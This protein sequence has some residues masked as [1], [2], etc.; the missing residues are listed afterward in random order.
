MRRTAAFRRRQF[1]GFI[2]RCNQIGKM[3]ETQLDE[4][5]QRLASFTIKIVYPSATAKAIAL[6]KLAAFAAFDEDQARLI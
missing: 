3:D 4:E 5:L 1:D 6:V 2:H